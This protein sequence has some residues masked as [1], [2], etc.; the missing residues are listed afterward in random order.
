MLL[1]LLH[2]LGLDVIGSVTFGALSEGEL[3]LA[4]NTALPTNLEPT[5]LRK[6]LVNKKNAQEKVIKNLTTAATY[7][8]VKGNSLSGWLEKVQN[9]E[10]TSGNNLQDQAKAELAKRQ[11]ANQGK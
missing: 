11:Q 8:N 6:Y 3:N 2:Q 9:M 1:V 10:S 7:L 5:E 4:L